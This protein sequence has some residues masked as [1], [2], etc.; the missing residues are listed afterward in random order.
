MRAPILM[1]AAAVGGLAA[2]TLTAF[3]ANGAPPPNRTAGGRAC[4]FHSDA[5][6]FSAPDDHTVYVRASVRDVYKIDLFGP[7]PNVDWTMGIGI[8]NRG[9]SWVCTGDTIDIVVPNHGIGP[10]RCM[11]KVVAKLTPEEVKA[12]PKKSRP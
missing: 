4:F 7:C 12:L 2:V 8:I 5:N 9:S 11:G 3:A 6:G 1:A 10:Q